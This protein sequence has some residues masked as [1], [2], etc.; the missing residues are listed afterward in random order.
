MAPG[1]A[2]T[3]AR[4]PGYSGFKMTARHAATPA[5]REWPVTTR[6]SGWSEWNNRGCG[7]G[8]NVANPKRRRTVD[9]RQRVR[10]AAA[11]TPSTNDGPGQTL[12]RRG[13]E[14]PRPSLAAASLGTSTR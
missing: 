6:D 5:P 14:G 13:N 9:V 4:R 3:Y 1:G 10:T 11:G 12:W 8:G 2:Y 7:H